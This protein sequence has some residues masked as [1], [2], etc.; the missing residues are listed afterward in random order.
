M[1]EFYVTDPLLINDQFMTG[2]C[3]FCNVCEALLNGLTQW[4]DHMTCKKHRKRIKTLKV[5]KRITKLVTDRA[6]PTLFQ[7]MYVHVAKWMA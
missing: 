3:V 6:H 4:K 2:R 1:Y 5:W 7:Q